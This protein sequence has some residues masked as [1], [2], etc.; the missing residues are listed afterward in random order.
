MQE[1]TLSREVSLNTTA[2]VNQFVSKVVVL[3]SASG[4]TIPEIF[5]LKCTQ[6]LQVPWESCVEAMQEFLKQSGIVEL[7][8]LSAIFPVSSDENNEKSIALNMECI[9]SWPSEKLASLAERAHA[10]RLCVGAPAL[11]QKI[12]NGTPY[13]PVAFLALAFL[14]PVLM[15]LACLR[16]NAS[17]WFHLPT[18][19]EVM[20]HPSTGLSIGNKF[21]KPLSLI[22][23]A[24][25]GLENLERFLQQA[26]SHPEYGSKVPTPLSTLVP[27]SAGHEVDREPVS[28]RHIHER[29]LRSLAKNAY[30]FYSECVGHL[31]H[32][33]SFCKE[34]WDLAD[35]IAVPIMKVAQEALETDSNEV[36]KLVTTENALSLDT[37]VNFMLVSTDEWRKV[38]KQYPH[39][40]SDDDETNFTDSVKLS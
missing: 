38:G 4:I 23:A 15:R 28:I 35:S 14:F 16:Q 9:S 18:L 19:K 36:T 26:A 6:P 29:D 30:E 40:F 31:E 12:A 22:V 32:F 20:A 2:D 11:F 24:R 21:D 17:V 34:G 7:E 25:H 37:L 1:L 10:F 5:M 33:R 3:W 8:G 13:F 27:D 39:L